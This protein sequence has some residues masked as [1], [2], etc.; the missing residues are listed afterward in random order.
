MKILNLDLIFA[1]YVR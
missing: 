1:L